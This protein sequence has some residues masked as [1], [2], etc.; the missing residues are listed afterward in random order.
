MAE[1]Y[2]HDE[3]ERESWLTWAIEFIAVGF[4][5]DEESTVHGPHDSSHAM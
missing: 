4:W 3:D 5:P 1:L 2:K